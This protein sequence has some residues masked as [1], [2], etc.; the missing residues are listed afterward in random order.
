M[1]DSPSGFP[2]GLLVI[3]DDQRRQRIIVPLEQRERLIKQEHLSLLHIGPERVA[4]ALTKRY[5]WH[6]MNDLVKR[7]VTSCHDC[8]V[9]RM[10]LQ[11]LSLEFAE[12]DA[13]QL[14]LPRQR[15]G[16][17]FHGH[18]KGE[19]LVA[20]D[21]VTREVCLW[22]LPN[23]KQEN[24]SRALLSG[25]VFVKGVPLEFRS[26][27]APE[28]MSGL[29]SAMNHYLGVEQITTGGYNP[30]GNAIVERFMHTLGHML[31]IASNEEYNNLKDY[32]QCIAFAH[33]CTYS[34]VIECTP[35][36]AGHG[37]RAR[38]VAEARMALP[39]LQLLEED[40]EDSPATQAW[41]KSLPKKVLELAARMA[42]IAQAHSEWHR[43]MTSEKLNQ[44]NRPFDDSQLQVGM[45]VY[46]YKPPSQQEVA[47]KG[48]KAKHLAHYHGPATVTVSRKRQLELRYEGKTFNR[49]ISLVIPAKDFTDLEVDSFD[50]V[51]TEAVSPPS[52]HV[53][54]ELPKEGELVVIKDSTTEGWFLSEVLRVLPN[55]VEVRYFTTPTPALENYEHCS[56]QKRSERLSEI[57]F[58]RTW[59][60]RFGKHVG[61]ATYKPP[62]PNNED[63]QVWK[64]AI[65]NSDLDSMLLLRNVRV[66]AE[67]KLD[68]ESLRLAAQLPISHEKLDTIEDELEG[69]SIIRQAPNLFT[70]SRETLCS[71]VECSRLLSRDY[72]VAQRTST[73]QQIATSQSSDD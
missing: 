25:L 40:S 60:V 6:K 59:H 36:E 14:P 28:L 65:N 13:N 63:L 19:I 38:T 16:I 4:R 51:V 72:T 39:K 34:S 52:R 9:S 21:L 20:I 67:G 69:S 47:A 37:L 23:R 45:R 56:V 33:N 70:S 26:D 2:D 27:N 1:L 11:R 17:D 50:P 35:F 62:Y 68:E 15:Y 12:A 66:D 29:V 48:R 18:A 71:C 44:A 32:L 42:A 46:F 8:Q 49:D 55:L 3:E 41:D 22:L 24:V 5:Y 73:E 7:I 43:R 53:V 30:R 61:R 31:R 64:G 54:G 57:C 58:R 10:R